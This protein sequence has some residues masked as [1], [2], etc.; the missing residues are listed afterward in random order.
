LKANNVTTAQRQAVR[1][2]QP[3]TVLE[4]SVMGNA[5]TLA[6]WDD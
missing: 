4:L 1:T 6:D 3:L 5:I 2:V